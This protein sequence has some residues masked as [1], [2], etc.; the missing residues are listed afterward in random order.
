[1]LRMEGFNVLT[2]ISGAKGLDMIR[3]TK[4]DVRLVLLD[5]NMPRLTGLETLQHVRK[6]V[7]GAKVLGLTG[8]PTAELPEDFCTNVDRLMAKPY[9]TAELVGCINELLE[10]PASEASQS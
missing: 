10:L 9:R 4:N 6:L 2:A 8:I 7:P 5:F 1:M 3:F